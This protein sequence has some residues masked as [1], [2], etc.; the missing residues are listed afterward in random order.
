MADAIGDDRDKP[1]AIR[2][3][4]SATIPLRIPQTDTTARRRESPPE[5][6]C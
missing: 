1:R 3:L 2:A 5:L 6:V 4:T